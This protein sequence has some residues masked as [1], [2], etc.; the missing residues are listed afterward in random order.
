[1]KK[2]MLAIGAVLA[3]MACSSKHEQNI[4]V[5][6]SLGF[7]RVGE[8]VEVPGVDTVGQHILL[9][10]EGQQVA[11]QLNGDTLLFQATV[12]A[13]QLANYCWKLGEPEVFA[14]Q[15]NCSFKSERKD[16]FFWEND[17]AG[18]R[19]YGP[20]LLPENP[21]NGVDL[22]YKS[23]TQLVGDSMYIRELEMDMPYHIYRGQGVDWY[24]VGHAV[25][26]GG[27]V[28]VAS[29]T[30]WVGGPYASYQILEQGPLRCRFAL[31]YDSVL[32]DSVKLQEDIV[33]TVEAGSQFNKAEVRFT[34]AE[35]P[36]LMAGAG[37]FLHDSVYSFLQHQEDGC[38][39]YAE[40]A[41]SD[42]G[43]PSIYEKY[44]AEL[45][46]DAGECYTAVYLPNL[47]KSGVYGKQLLALQSYKVGETYTY[48]FGGEWSKAGRCKSDKEWFEATDRSRQAILSP[49]KVTIK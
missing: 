11:Y 18:Y 16:D 43:V 39:A 31:H 3:L 4:T 10:A 33:I 38:I 22:W 29:D 44:K 13:A 28:L 12:P 37:I 41:I 19:M 7:D 47:Q 2:F 46:A 8:L 6:N 45:P 36:N 14:A 49:L 21:S 25:G 15:V 34:G 9:N 48:Y 26:C 27:V 32:V 24:K 42:G 20:A 17:R 23:C 5:E 30:C 1:M 35:V 40:P